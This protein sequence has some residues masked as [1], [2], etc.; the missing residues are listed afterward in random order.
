MK[1]KST[2]KTPA[3]KKPAKRTPKK[4]LKAPK[5]AARKKSAAKEPASALTWHDVVSILGRPHDDPRVVDIVQQLGIRK[6][7]RF[8]DVVYSKRFGIELVFEEAQRACVPGF[9]ADRLLVLRIAFTVNEPRDGGMWK[10][11][12]P[13]WLDRDSTAADIERGTRLN[14]YG[15][16]EHAVGV[17]DNGVELTLLFAPLRKGKR[18]ALVEVTASPENYEH[19]RRLHFVDN[20]LAEQGPE[21]FP[22]CLVGHDDELIWAALEERIGAKATA[23]RRA[24]AK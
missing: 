11:E 18:H 6:R 5:V 22:E 21:A 10:G 7:P 4:G 1:K 24:L 14:G 13:S 15:E 23:A 2:R 19:G 17:I 12:L 16:D 20:I 3:A 8:E 9:P